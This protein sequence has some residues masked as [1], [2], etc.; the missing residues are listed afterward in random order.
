MT[1][2]GELLK[3]GFVQTKLQGL[4]KQCAS[5]RKSPAQPSANC[6]QLG[7]LASKASRSPDPGTQDEAVLSSQ[8]T[9]WDTF[10]GEASFHKASN[11]LPVNFPF[12]RQCIPMIEHCQLPQP[13]FK[14]FTVGKFPIH[15]FH[16]FF[17][18]FL[19]II[20]LQAYFPKWT[21]ELLWLSLSYLS[22]S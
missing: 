9:T 20:K 5:C 6:I 17:P 7:S 18:P 12:R 19:I 14:I 3:I 1:L 21:L 15:Y 22:F 4:S 8:S 16:Y 11:G 10:W 13:Q 2:F